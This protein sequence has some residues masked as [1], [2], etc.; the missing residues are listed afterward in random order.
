MG[1][2]H[3]WGLTLGD[4][5]ADKYSTE[6]SDSVWQMIYLFLNKFLNLHSQNTIAFR[7]TRTIS[8]KIISSKSSWMLFQSVRPKMYVSVETVEKNAA[9]IL[10]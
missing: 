10:I 2:L 9:E 3:F 5:F 4:K 1:N 6:K 7:I 8:D